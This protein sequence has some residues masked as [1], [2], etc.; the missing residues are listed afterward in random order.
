MRFWCAWRSIF[1]RIFTRK[2]HVLS[3][4]FLIYA[5]VKSL[6]SCTSLH[7]TFAGDFINIYIV[8]QEYY[9]IL[10]VAAD[11]VRVRVHIFIQ[12]AS[13]RL[14]LQFAEVLIY[15]YWKR[16]SWTTY[17]KG[18]KFRCCEPNICTVNPVDWVDKKINS[19]YCETSDITFHQLR[20]TS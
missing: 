5:D 4:V 2:W 3:F 20:P 9:H 14:R 10:S 16:L 15:N 7:F 11:S 17:E 12:C 19:K 18:Q 1:L 6:S 8:I 13:C